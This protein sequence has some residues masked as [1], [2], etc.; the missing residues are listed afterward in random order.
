MTYKKLNLTAAMQILR[1]AIAL[2]TVTFVSKP[3]DAF[4]PDIQD[5]EC[6][7]ADPIPVTS[8]EVNHTVLNLPDGSYRLSYTISWEPLTQ[9]DF[10]VYLSDLQCETHENSIIKWIFPTC[11]DTLAAGRNLS[12]K[13]SQ[14]AFMSGDAPFT[15][16]CLFQVAYGV[17]SEGSPLPVSPASAMQFE[18]P[19]CY[20]ETRDATFCAA[21]D[22]Y[23]CG[24]PT[25]VSLDHVTYTSDGNVSMTFIWSPPV[26]VNSMRTL[27]EYQT[28][29]H[30]TDGDLILSHTIQIYDSNQVNTW[31]AISAEIQEG[32]EYKLTIIPYVL[33]DYANNPEPGRLATKLFLAEISEEDFTDHPFTT[34]QETDTIVRDKASMGIQSTSF[35]PGPKPTP[36]SVSST[37][38]TMILIIGLFAVFVIVVVIVCFLLTKRRRRIRKDNL[39][40]LHLEQMYQ[41]KAIEKT[42]EVDPIL[43]DKEISHDKVIIEQKLGEGEFGVVHMGKVTGMKNKVEDVTVAIKTTKVGAFSDVKEDLIN[44]MKLIA[45]LGDHVNILCLLA[46]CSM[47][48]PFYLI[49]EYMKYGDLLGFLRDCRKL[50]S[51]EKDQVYSVGELQQL[52]IARDIANGMAH[53]Q[54]RRFYHGDL[55]ARN[56]L[57]GEGLAI[58]ISDFGLADDIYTRGYKRRATEQKIPVK[59]CS[60]ETII[61]GI[62]SSE[63]DAWSFGVLLYEIFTLG[64]TPYPGI[65]PRLLVSQLKNGYRMDQPDSCPDDVY[66]LMKRCWQESPMSRPKFTNMFEEFGEMLMKRTDYLEFGSEDV[67]EM[68]ELLKLPRRGS[69]I[70]ANHYISPSDEGDAGMKLPPILNEES[71]VDFDEVQSAL[72][73]ST[74][75]KEENSTKQ[76]DELVMM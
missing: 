66:D 56:V 64:G 67:L 52:I 75:D 51:A 23:R 22:V 26:Q 70:Q 54:E 20:E 7:D 19:D 15:H 62:C 8:I 60:L 12:D 4:V 16:N 53:I 27:E 14:S 58:K 59:W 5:Y 11:K 63:G 18:T 31:E 50:A 55:A 33:S 71:E 76:D 47:N 39:E 49:T 28:Q 25:D 21:Q 2:A 74:S 48:E 9:Y 35:A 24:K 38:T 45:E 61:N 6:I 43:T 17:T 72:Q 69:T 41:E 3:C 42:R 32:L 10:I 13:L 68:E 1:V 44:E 34:E 37:S 40:N 36:E 46:C 29:L 65:A 57:V 30:T 73:Q